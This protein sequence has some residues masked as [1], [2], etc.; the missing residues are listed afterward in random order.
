MI[1]KANKIE[2]GSNCL[3]D[4]ILAIAFKDSQTPTA[5]SRVT[6]NDTSLPI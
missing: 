6:F 3:D 5:S 2:C 1:F 4:H